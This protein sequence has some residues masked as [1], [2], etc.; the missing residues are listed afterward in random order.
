MLQFVLVEKSP[1]VFTLRFVTNEEL[2]DQLRDQGALK[3]FL[4][5]ADQLYADFRRRTD[6]DRAP[7]RP[8]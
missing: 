6:E 2:L 1:S 7:A 3:G 4:E 5:D 8:N